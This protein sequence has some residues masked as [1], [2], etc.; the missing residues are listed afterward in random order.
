MALLARP[1]G[2][3]PEDMDKLDSVF[4]APG[5]VA[6]LISVFCAFGG[7]ALLLPVVPLAVIDAGGSDSLA[8]LSTGVFMVATV[9]TQAF[10]PAILRR[11]GHMPVM[12]LAS[13]LLGAPAALYA[14][15]MSPAMV[16]GVAVV[17]GIGFGAVTVA[18]AA[19]IAELVPPRLVGRSSG[20]FGATVG[21]TQ[22]VAF[23]LGMWLYSTVG[24]LVFVLALVYSVVGAMAAIGLPILRRHTDPAVDSESLDFTPP[25]PR[26]A[27]WK[28]ATVPGLCIAVAAAGF[29]AFSTF[30]APAIGE[31]DAGAAA[32]IAGLTLSVMGGMQIITRLGSGWWADRVGEPG[33]LMVAGLVL[34]LLG[35]VVAG[36]AISWELTGWKILVA[37]LGAAALFGAGFG[38]AQTEALLMMFHRLPREKSAL[39][40]ALWNMT[41]D[42]GTGI[43]ATVLGVVAGAFAYQGA[44]FIAAA[45]VVVG[46]VVAVLDHVVGRHR[47]T[48]HG[49]VRERLRRVVRRSVS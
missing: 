31:L 34:S 12:A 3:S 47:V 15:D 42:S 48:D 22:L 7:W 16:L 27:T 46:I 40:S 23:P 24:S 41:F 30:M 43:G 14:L 33:H 28:L 6:T 44:F 17:R 37:A 26:A 5:L 10:T 36:V 32:T 45:F 18:E 29:A 9:V 11:V 49:N 21:V 13:L 4:K 20:V 2:L 1:E 19:L 39:A 25:E 8:G 35:L 38:V